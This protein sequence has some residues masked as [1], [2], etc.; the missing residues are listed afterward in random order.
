[1]SYSNPMYITPRRNILQRLANRL[2]HR[3]GI[4]P[5]PVAFE[6]TLPE[7]GGKPKD[8]FNSVYAANYW[9][10][11]ES[12]SGSG[13]TLAA[14]AGYVPQLI[15]AINDLGIETMFDA[16]CG[17]LNWMGTVIDRTGV[18]YQGGD[19]ADEAISIAKSRRP[20]LP[21]ARF[22]ICEDDFPAVD[23]W[24]C[25]DTFF[26]LS[27]E[28]ISKALRQL[29]ASSIPYAALT[30]HRARMLRNMDIATGGFRLLD[31]ERAPFNFPPALRY[32]RDYKPG[33]FP[34]FVGIWRVEDLRS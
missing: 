5:F 17:D 26:H 33:E 4:K 16:P 29:T 13:S 18:A 19:I 27:Y 1:M 24:H 34:R 10:D 2:G 11:H 7:A 21:I 31:L 9:E 28:A 25:R 14:T 23:L 6:S 3:F 30:T 15:A 32:L 12:K 22:D 8:V 20:D